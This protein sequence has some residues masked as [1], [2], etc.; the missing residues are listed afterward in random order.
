MKRSKRV[1]TSHGRTSAE[2]A[3]TKRDEFTVNEPEREALSDARHYSGN[4][5]SRRKDNRVDGR[6]KRRAIYISSREFGDGNDWEQFLEQAK[7]DIS[8]EK[9]ESWL[10]RRGWEHDE[11]YRYANPKGYLLYDAQRYHYRSLPSKKMFVLRH[12]N[13]ND[14]WVRGAGPVR[15][16]YN[17]PELLNRPNDDI[18]LV[19]GEKA[20]NDLKRKGL[21]ATCVQGQNWTEDVAQFFASRNVN[22]V[23][24]N[25]DAGREHNKTALHWLGKE[26]AQVRIITLPGLRP[27]GGLDDWLKDHSIE[28]YQ[29]LVAKT[30]VA[31]RI[32]VKPHDFPAENEIPRY[33]WLLG[34]HLLRGEVAG[35]AAMGGTGKSILSIVEALAM[36]SGK[37]LTY[38]TVPSRPLRVVL[39]N[40][41]DKRSTMNKRIAAAMRHYKLTQADI[42]DRLIVLAKGE[43]KFKIAKLTRTGDVER[44]MEVIEQLTALMLEKHADVLSIDSFIRTHSVPEN[45]NTAIEQ[46]IECFEDIAESANCG[47]HLWHHTRKMGGE[48]ASVEAARGAQAF[49]DACRSVRILETMSRKE[50]DELSA[51]LP[52]IGEPGYYFRAFN[53]KRNFAPPSDQS[54]W[55]KYE[56]VK[57]NNLT[58]EFEDDGDNV[59]V[60]TPW[61]Y[62][63]ID[64]PKI[65]PADVDRA[66]EAV[67]AGGPWRSNSSSTKEPWVGVP[68]AKVLLIDLLN[69]FAKRAVIGL[70]KELFKTGRLKRV[71]GRDDHYEVREY[72][73][74]P[75]EEASA[76]E[77]GDE[78]S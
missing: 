75:A 35:T 14:S 69:P 55:F 22:V 74:A 26:Q 34:R 40:L 66:L 65:T 38:D 68:I 19:E 33:E 64:L 10:N 6:V 32:A 54:D 29:A 72:V 30:P 28:E 44:N 18:T 24:D 21:L 46:V 61:Q 73:E 15:V 50:R 45:N 60:V 5:D 20:V 41:E 59:G 12:R 62:P 7:D 1:G 31:G 48:K 71:K 52:D 58:S 63:K 11:D 43:L 2:G 70:I 78:N 77:N 4:F 76:G 25:D 23:M 36:T 16:P 57:L 49:I 9:Y 67:R 37:Q 8:F 3:R 42:G 56:S 17:L 27:R 39:I 51:I 47:V 53:G 13:E